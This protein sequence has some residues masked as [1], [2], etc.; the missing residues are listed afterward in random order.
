MSVGLGRKNWKNA[1]RASYRKNSSC[2]SQPAESND[3]ISTVSR[4][5][6]TTLSIDRRRAINWR[7][8]PERWG[9]P[10]L[11]GAGFG[12]RAG[13]DALVAGGCGRLGVEVLIA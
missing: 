10:T 7:S 6:T 2:V 11:S 8:Q 9:T 3:M 5:P 13:G 1:A 4:Q 12:C